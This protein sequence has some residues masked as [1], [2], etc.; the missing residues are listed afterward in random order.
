MLSDLLF[1]GLLLLG[2]LWL[3]VMLYHAWPSDCPAGYQRTPQPAKPPRKRS[4]APNRFLASPVSLAVRPVSRRPRNQRPRCLPY[5]RR[6]SLPSGDGR[7]RWTPRGNSARNQT[8]TIGAG[9]A[10]AISVSTGIPAV[11]PGASCTAPPVTVTCCRHTARCFMAGA[12]RPICWCGSCAP[13]PK[14][15]AS[16]P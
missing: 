16:A 5:R 9:W 2:L 7:A 11:A 3:C 12:S 8:A 15:W 13:W 10:G 14:G 6:R 4:H 1:Y